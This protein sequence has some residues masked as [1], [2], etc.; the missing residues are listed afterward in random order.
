MAL[1]L[2]PTAFAEAPSYPGVSLVHASYC[3]HCKTY[4]P[5]FDAFA[6]Q[7]G[8]IKGGEASTTKPLVTKIDAHKY[9]QQLTNGEYPGMQE[10]RGFPT[11]IFY[12]G[13]GSTYE[14]YKGPRTV[15]G[16]KAGWKAFQ[17][18]V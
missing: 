6:E 9:K 13:D 17:Q 16:L 12:S 10:V 11:T 7:F 1:S 8:T 4:M 5:T 2:K 15:E 14:Q 3:H 18:N